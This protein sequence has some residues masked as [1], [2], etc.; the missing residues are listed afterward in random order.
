MPKTRRTYNASHIDA[1]VDALSIAVDMV[2]YAVVDLPG[3]LDSERLR[4]ALDRVAITEPLFAARYVRSPWIGSWEVDPEPKWHL[5]EHEEVDES[6]ATALEAAMVRAPYEFMDAL[7]VEIDLLHMTDRDRLLVRASHLLVDAGGTKNILYRLAAAY[8]KLGSEPGW[9]PEPGRPGPRSNLRLL[10]ALRPSNLWSTFRGWLADNLSL[11]PTQYFFAP[12]T[13]QPMEQCDRRQIGLHLDR[14]RTSRLKERWGPTG[15]TINDIL[16]SA[17][18]R[19]LERSFAG[20]PGQKEKLALAIT[21]DQ[22][23]HIVPEEHLCNFSTLRPFPIGRLPLPDPTELLPRIAEGTAAWKSRGSGLGVSISALAWPGMLPHGLTRWFF[24]KA[25]SFV[26][27]RWGCSVGLTNMGPIDGDRIDFGDGP[28]LAARL[29]P[30]VGRPPMLVTGATGCAGAVD[31]TLCY[32]SPTLGAAEAKG[33][34]ETMDGE[35]TRLE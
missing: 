19:S 3:R 21:S 18:A 12:L 34:I 26:R 5:V 31:F 35:L 29:T 25:F 7:P 6:G 24:A 33:L 32:L 16:L 14:A 23:K 22:R 1:I 28:C 11:L 30:P 2:I 8:R 4:D 15:V 10:R 17:Y 27:R 13:P 20:T 9:R